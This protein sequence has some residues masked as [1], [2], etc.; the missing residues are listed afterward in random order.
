MR[1]L[2]VIL[3]VLAVWLIAG[4]SQAEAVLFGGD[5]LSASGIAIGG[6]GSGSAFEASDR[7]LVGSRSIKVTTQGLHEGARIDFKNP[8]G[9]ISDGISDEDY[10]QFAFSFTT[11]ATGTGPGFMGPGFGAISMPGG[12]MPMGPG[13]MYQDMEVPSKTKINSVRLVIESA[14]G[15]SIEASQD[16]PPAG[17]DGW[18]RVAVPFKYLG[19]KQGDSFRVSRVLVFTDVPDTFYVGEIAAVRDTT[20]IVADPGEEQDVAIYDIVS[21]RAEAEGGACS[22]RYSWNFGDNG[23]DGED[24]T[25]EIV[26]HKYRKGG[27]FTVRLTVTDAWGIKKPVITTTTATVN[28]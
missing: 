12:G 5:P 3:A 25:G 15:K 24:A 1:N 19:L 11:V 26:S 21:F 18:Y 28:D 6:W 8:V 17:E 16:V 10:L 13:V 2:C 27:E 9:L 4:S 7:V 20:P 22:L 14:D 23:T